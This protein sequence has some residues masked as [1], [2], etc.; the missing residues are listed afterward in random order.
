MKDLVQNRPG[1][2]AL[3]AHVAGMSDAD[4]VDHLLYVVS[5][6]LG[7][8]EP[9]DGLRLPRLTAKEAALMRFLLAREGW[10]VTRAQLLTALWPD[11][12][13]PMPLAVDQIVLRLR[14]KLPPEFKIR[15]TR[16]VGFAL[17]RCA[18]DQKESPCQP[19]S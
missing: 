3:R 13:E 4:A 6:L 11:G 19:H 12:D 8:S 15:N 7:D 1:F 9:L 2:E 10:V 18:S 16:D 17:H 14:R 5:E